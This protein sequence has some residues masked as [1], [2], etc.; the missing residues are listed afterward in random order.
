MAIQCLIFNKDGQVHCFIQLQCVLYK[1]MILMVTLIT[2][3]HTL[4][5]LNSRCWLVDIS[6]KYSNTALL[7]PIQ[8]IAYWNKMQY[9]IFDIKYTPLAFLLLKIFFSI[10]LFF[11]FYLFQ[12]KNP[13][14][15]RKL[16]SELD[17]YTENKLSLPVFISIYFP[18]KIPLSCTT[19]Q[20]KLDCTCLLCHW[21]ILVSD[22]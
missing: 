7:S 12:D 21:L 20:K 6:V 1:I 14:M 11:S 10:Y 18:Q 22:Q 17:V 5:I 4:P 13:I 2:V 8:F 16:Q 9:E 15:D 3:F 19:D